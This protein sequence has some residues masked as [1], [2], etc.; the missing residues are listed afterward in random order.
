[1][2]HAAR[3]L[4]SW[5]IFDVGRNSMRIS[6]TPIAVISAVL[7]LAGCMDMFDPSGGRY[8]RGRFVD[9]QAFTIQ[10]DRATNGGR[11]FIFAARKPT[12]EIKLRSVYLFSYLAPE[13]RNGPHLKFEWDGRKKITVFVSS[14]DL[15]KFS[16]ISIFGDYRNPE[17]AI[18]GARSVNI[19]QEVYF[20][21]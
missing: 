7:L 5:L 6:I 2:S 1:M 4:P 9:P 14:E 3:Q 18:S 20:T 11:T 19:A 17:S 16:G 10:E 21:K 15:A 12:A 8:A 13:R